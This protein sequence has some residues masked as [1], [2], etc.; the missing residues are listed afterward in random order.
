MVV[1][2]ATDFDSYKHFK[3]NKVVAALETAKKTR[4]SYS[5]SE[6]AGIIIE[7]EKLR[8]HFGLNLS[9]KNY[10][11]HKGVDASMLSKWKK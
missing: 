8:E 5:I 10:P 11:D 1:V 6:K 7:F 9:V 3:S 2:A 4:V